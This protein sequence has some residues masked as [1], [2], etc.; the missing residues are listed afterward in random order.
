MRMYAAVQAYIFLTVTMVRKL[1]HKALFAFHEFKWQM[2]WD[3]K[4]SMESFKSLFPSR[5]LA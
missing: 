3:L 1:V 2:L 4:E 5:K